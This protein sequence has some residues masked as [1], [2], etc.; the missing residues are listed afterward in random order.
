MNEFN[1]DIVED[2]AKPVTPEKDPPS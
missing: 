1:R 2:D